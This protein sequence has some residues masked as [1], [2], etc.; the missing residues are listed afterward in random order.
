MDEKNIKSINNSYVN[1]NFYN[2]LLLDDVAIYST[3]S[4]SDSNYIT[5][6][7]SKYMLDNYKMMNKDIV[8]T[9]ATGGVGGNTISFGKK[10]K[11]VNTVEINKNRV[12]LLNINVSLHSLK[13]VD[14]YNSNYINIFNK[15]SQN[16]VFID[17]PWGGR[18][19]KSKNNVKL[20]LSNMRIEDICNELKNVKLIVLK[21]PLNFDFNYFL[22][23]IKYTKINL[24]KMNKMCIMMIKV[25]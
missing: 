19:Y 3:T 12:Y 1:N 14:I 20:T 25:I 4:Q 6:M 13:N 16:I 23:N 11:K 9:D 7:I 22:K 21:V 24:I 18:N 17:A 5:N 8:I 10:F 15:L 2:Y